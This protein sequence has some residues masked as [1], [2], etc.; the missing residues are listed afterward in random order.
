MSSWVKK[1]LDP[2]KKNTIHVTSNRYKEN[3]IYNHSIYDT[4]IIGKIT[5]GI[6]SIFLKKSICIVVTE[7]YNQI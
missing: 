4:V 2:V 6:C 3:G 1:K 5:T 7:L